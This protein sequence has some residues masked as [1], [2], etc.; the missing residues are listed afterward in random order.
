[1]GLRVRD[2]P[3]ASTVKSPIE[4]GE[5]PSQHSV[6]VGDAGAAG[7]LNSLAECVPSEAVYER[8]A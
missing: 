1:M 4:L 3:L 7:V 6:N 5:S 8:Q 2:G